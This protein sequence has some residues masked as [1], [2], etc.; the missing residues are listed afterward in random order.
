MALKLFEFVKKF[1]MDTFLLKLT[2]IEKTGSVGKI[3]IS[4]GNLI[5]N[6]IFEIRSRSRYAKSKLSMNKF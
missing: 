1:M 2:Q 4:L 3:F 6:S 5:I